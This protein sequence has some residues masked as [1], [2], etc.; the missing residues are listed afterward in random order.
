[1][2]G[3]FVYTNCVK[4]SYRGALSKRDS[5]LNSARNSI[6]SQ[7]LAFE[8]GQTP[9]SSE[10]NYNMDNPHE[11]PLPAY[12]PLFSSFFFTKIL[13]LCFLF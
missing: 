12:S 6:T 10:S 11:P 13:F 7:G 4:P 3:Q 2:F 5:Q 8:K 1:M 9:E